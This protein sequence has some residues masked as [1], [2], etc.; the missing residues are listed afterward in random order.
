MNAGR[1]AVSS[2]VTPAMRGYITAIAHL[3]D[4]T[5]LV[6]TQQLAKQL[7]VSAPTVTNMV[8]RMCTRGLVFR[9]PYHGVQLTLSGQR[10]AADIRR[11]RGSLER[12]LVERLGYPTDEARREA[13]RLE[14]HATADL[15]A[16]V[17]AALNDCPRDRR[18]SDSHVPLTCRTE[19]PAKS[20]N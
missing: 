19:I 14:R 16:H 13:V 8:K 4:G 15:V 10:I 20:Q 3:D 6:T 2:S 11:R 7:E 1:E 18:E 12:Y 5:G 17:D 9:D